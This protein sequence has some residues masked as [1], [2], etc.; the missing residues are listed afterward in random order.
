LEGE[1]F[2]SQLSTALCGFDE[3]YDAYTKKMKPLI[4]LHQFER[5]VLKIKGGFGEELCTACVVS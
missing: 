2:I 5:K 3:V 4:D 1:K